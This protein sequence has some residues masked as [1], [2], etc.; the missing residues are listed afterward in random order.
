MRLGAGAPPPSRPGGE[1]E[2]CDERWNP[3]VTVPAPRGVARTRNCTGGRSQEQ[4]EAD[5]VPGQR[6]W[7]YADIPPWLDTQYQDTMKDHRGANPRWRAG[8]VTQAM[9]KASRNR[10]RPY[11]EYKRKRIADTG[12]STLQEK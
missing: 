7:L 3:G 2:T 10:L 4:V 6:A 11:A 9:E 1:A 8:P 12:S 5:P